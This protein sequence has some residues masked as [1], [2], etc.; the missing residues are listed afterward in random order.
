MNL[1]QTLTPRLPRRYLLFIA[2][3]VWTFAGGMLLF[4]GMLLFNGTGHYF[5]IRLMIS[6]I[7]GVLFYRLLF[8]GIS[9]K[10]TRRIIELPLEKP[11]LFSFFNIRSYILMTVMITAGVTLRKSGIMPQEYL[12]M[13]YVTMG[14]PLLASSVRFYNAGFFKE[15]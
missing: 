7:G 14:I 9:R 4:R 11:C 10:H 15:Y 12:S 6:I 13:L 8:S 2:A 3:A 1:L 5:W